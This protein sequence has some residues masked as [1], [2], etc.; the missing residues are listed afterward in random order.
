MKKL[1]S[2]RLK[3]WNATRW[4]GR[5][6]CLETICHVYHFVLDHLRI[7]KKNNSDKDTQKKAADLYQRLTCYD[8]FL[9]IHFYRDLALR[10]G[11]TSQQLQRKELQISHVGKHILALSKRLKQYF[12]PDSDYPNE[13]LGNGVTDN[14]IRELF[15][16]Q[17]N[18]TL[19]GIILLNN[20]NKIRIDGV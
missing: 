18:D 20:I 12:P 1:P 2:L 4:L 11:T 3:R 19:K 15:D 9:F 10:M 8:T 14:V 7:E 5:V 16:L 13:L 6:E 17:P